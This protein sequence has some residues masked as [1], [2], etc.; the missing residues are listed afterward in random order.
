MLKALVE[1]LVGASTARPWLVAGAGALLAVLAVLY[2][3]AH[4]AMTTD[5]A[6]LIS[7][8]VEWRRN[9]AVLSRAFPQQNDLSVVVVD[10]R[11]PELAEDAAARL[12]ERLSADK[13]HFL[14]VQRP[15]GGGF[16]AREGLLLQSLTDVRSTTEGLI[17]AQPFLGPLAAD[18]S[19]RGVAAA[20]G[21]LAQGVEQGQ[22]SLA[23]VQAPLASLAD[24]VEGVDA[25]KPTFFS[26]QAMMGATGGG[27]SA[28]RRRFIL[29]RPKLDYGDLTPGAAATDAV[30]AAARELKLDA[31]HG[32]TV[33]VT[34]SVP[35]SDEEFASLSDNV[36]LVSGAM[37]GSVLLML[38]LAVRSVRIMAAILIT[39]L[40]GL[41][42][43]A[44]TGLLTVG[45]FNLISVAFIPLFVGLGIDFGIQIGVR[46]RAERLDE[47]S[48]PAALAKAASGIGAALALAAAAVTLGFLAFLPTSYVGV[49]E[50]G[51]IAGCGMVIGLVLNTTL[52]PALLVLLNPPDQGRE[53]GSRAMA[54]LDRFMHERRRLVLGAFVGATVVSVA[55][56][57][58]VR[59][60]FN[61]FHLRNAKGEA[62]STFA[63][64]TRDPTQTLN[65]V[66]A[67]APSPAAAEALAQRLSKLPQ[68][69]QAI[70]L[71]SF[72][73]DDQ[74]A[75]LAL[76]ADANALLDPTL[77]P[78]DVRPPPSDAET[79]GALRD[80]AAA[81]GRI[82]AGGT[83]PSAIAARRLSA[84]MAR[85]A[86][87]P[88]ERRGAAAE[89]LV[90][91]LNVLLGQVRALLTAEP[92]T[93]ESLPQD[94]RRDWVTPDGRARVQVFPK[95]DSNDNAVLKRFAAAVRAVAPGASGAPISVQE[96]G[97]TISQAFIVAGLLSLAAICALLLLAL[98]SVKEVAFTLAPIV[99]SGFLT[100]ATCVII[101]Q[102]INFANI[103]AFPLLFGV[104][105][106]FHI[107]F[108]MAWR[109]GVGDLLQ[110]S[111]ARAVF[112]SA[113]TTGMAFGALIFSSHP[114]TA[115]MGKILMISLV[116]TLV[117]A[118]LF[119][120]ALLGPPAG[121][122]EG[123]AHEGPGKG[124]SAETDL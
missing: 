93:L 63:D 52:L 25:G 91:P 101:G 58:L 114:G 15:D 34:G 92:V 74:P 105:V 35:L 33:R 53:V 1:R 76:I 70:T 82:A 19:L 8:K 118:L 24:A 61:P 112:F 38:W 27:L 31:A 7:P 115:S 43:T 98:R 57:P 37:L 89:T 56:L 9:E 119:E 111:L 21:A 4:F 13:A 46:F 79:V 84:A 121:S 22:A 110:S 66:D 60:D 116:W 20:F 99:L 30:H 72:V 109:S 36:W 26:W 12:A 100:L 50:L 71:T 123:P 14:G 49:S 29:L 39:T 41:V 86:D 83:E 120:P 5:T 45:R 73:P 75:K 96:A 16:F 69:E 42:A 64:L 59:F 106:A 54:P 40:V 97:K 6:E 47:P 68:V 122:R 67:L 87:G 28:P 102:P 44:A 18:P 10:G 32:Q 51:V 17:R 94:L 77:N 23:D 2:A 48:I 108:V 3:G 124:R 11:T 85:L 88:A 65:T 107:Y 103:I 78:F 104:G 95:G 62:M 80:T 90:K 55:L 117:T 81:L 113:M